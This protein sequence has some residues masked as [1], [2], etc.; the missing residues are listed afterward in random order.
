MKFGD[1]PSMEL[2]AKHE[3]DGKASMRIGK[4]LRELAND[5]ALALFG[6]G[7]IAVW[8]VGLLGRQHGIW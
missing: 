5:A 3:A 6:L 8:M 4:N 2:F 7:C 1:V